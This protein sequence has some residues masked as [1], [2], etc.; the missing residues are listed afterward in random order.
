MEYNFEEAVAKLAEAK[1]YEDI[2]A[3]MKEAFAQ[4]GFTGYLFL[5][6]IF[7]SYANVPVIGLINVSREWI[8][9][10]LQM[11]YQQVDPLGSYYLTNNLPYVWDAKAD[12]SS[13]GPEAVAFMEDVLSFGF[14]GGLLAG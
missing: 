2:N 9:H 10:Y 11:N 14:T 13:F 7:E 12:W 1:S 5:V 4:L 8:Y 6:H 3:V